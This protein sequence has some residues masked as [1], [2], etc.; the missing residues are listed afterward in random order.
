MA[1]LAALLAVSP[2]VAQ[3]KPAP[4]QQATT[5]VFTTTTNLVNL[6]LRA[7][8]PGGA[9]LLDLKPGDFE[10]L[11]DG[12]PQHLLSFAPASSTAAATAN[13]AAPPANFAAPV[14]PGGAGSAAAIRPRAVAFVLN[15]FSTDSADH[16]RAAH[17]VRHWLRGQGRPLLFQGFTTSPADL[18]LFLRRLSRHASFGQGLQMQQLLRELKLC[19][20]LPGG[21]GRACGATAVR[22]FAAQARNCLREQYALL[23]DIVRFL[24]AFPGE[25]AMVYIGDGFWVHPN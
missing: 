5:P 2:L 16:Q 19:Q 7:T 20:S 11:E 8:G 15:G 4:A 24:G 25:R 21:A 14:G 3:N 1:L 10:I 6:T 9:P 12:Q 17:A 22:V 23:R 13:P 18:E